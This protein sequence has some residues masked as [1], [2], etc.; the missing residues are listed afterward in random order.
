MVY[1]S[2][3]TI[4]TSNVT[5]KMFEY[6]YVYKKKKGTSVSSPSPSFTHTSTRK[7]MVR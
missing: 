1:D 2:N 4:Y 6:K 3:R 5:D 7:V